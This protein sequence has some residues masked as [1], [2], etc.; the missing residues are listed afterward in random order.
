[1]ATEGLRRSTRVRKT[2]KSYAVE[3]AEETDELALKAPPPKRKKKNAATDDAD[4]QITVPDMSS[5]V[6]VTKAIKN[7]SKKVKVS[8][9][10]VDEPASSQPSK[11]RKKVTANTNWHAEAAEN[12]IIRTKQQTKKLAPGKEETRLRA[13]VDVPSDKYH[14]FVE[15][16]NTQRMFIIDRERGVEHN[17]HANH[18][19]CPCETVQIAGSTGNV[20][21]VTISHMPSCSCPVGIFRKKGEEI[22]CKH[23]L[24]VLHHVLKAPDE[25]KYQNAFLTSELRQIFTNAPALPSEVADDEPKDGN[26][27][28]VEDD[29]P[30]CCMEF[31]ADEEIVWCRAACGNNVHKGCFDQ[32]ANT[33]RGNVTCPFCRTP[34]QSA[35]APKKQKVGVANIEVS[36]ET[37]AAG[38]RN[39]R[40]LLEYE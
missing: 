33:K 17:C 11:K 31:E 39:V 8:K 10:I 5:D 38:Y 4:V 19:D 1:M 16:A 23:I 9:T 6:E 30:I 35:D 20:Y 24:Y 7:G 21:T 14:R 28:P 32:W 37:G 15:S 3:Q 29:C 22:C 26:R 36:S 34:W 25:L 27:K 18:E 12:R 40:H 2:V 13:Y